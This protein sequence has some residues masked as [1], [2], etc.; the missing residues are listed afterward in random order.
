MQ[1]CN[2]YKLYSTK[3]SDKDKKI[4]NYPRKEKRGNKNENTF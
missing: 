2:L 3:I 1:S 4:V